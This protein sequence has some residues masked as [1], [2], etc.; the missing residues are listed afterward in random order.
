M[1]EGTEFRVFTLGDVARIEAGSEVEDP[2][3]DADVYLQFD[4]D[5]AERI[6]RQLVQAA[7]E[8]RNGS[9]GPRPA[10]NF[11]APVE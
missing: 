10:N 9:G 6:G 8:A 4:A 1:A 5:T 11:G 7:A 2:E 3:A